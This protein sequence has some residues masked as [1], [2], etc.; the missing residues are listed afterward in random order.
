MVAVLNRWVRHVP[1]WTLYLAGLAHI[2]WLFWLG[3]TGGLGP[4]PIN[5]LERALGETGLKLIIVGLAITPVMKVARIN[6]IRFRR[7]IGLTAFLYISVHLLVWL[8]LDVFLLSEIWADI[9]KRPYITVGM[10]GFAL[11]VPL[12]VTSNDWSV[13]RMGAAAW[14]RL[15]RLTYAAAVLGAVH[16]V[17]LAKTWAAE[18]LTY[19]AVMI[20][21]LVL[22][23]RWRTKPRSGN[24]GG[25]G[26]ARQGPE[27][28]GKGMSA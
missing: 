1:P 22:R 20:A 25:M 8:L 26:R 15:H 3:E 6:L 21:L 12:A 16:N 7:A 2:V 11:L 28:V 14:K 9:V 4:E 24:A 19:L 23:L 13:R 10:A 18:P 5:A 17:M 27:P